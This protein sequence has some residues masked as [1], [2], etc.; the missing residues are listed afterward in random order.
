MPSRHY[1]EMLVEKR[2]LADLMV[3][4]DYYHQRVTQMY[5]LGVRELCYLQLGGYYAEA[6][7]VV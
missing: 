5:S 7:K 2:R 4:H 6:A 3:W 1:G